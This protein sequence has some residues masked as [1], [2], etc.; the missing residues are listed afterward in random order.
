MTIPLWVIG[1]GG[2]ASVVI[3][4]ARASGQF[5]IAGVLDDDARRH[6]A[7]VLGEPVRGDSS[8]ETVVALSV[9]HVVIAIGANPV[10]QRVAQRLDGLVRWARVVH[11]AAIVAPDVTIGP[12]SV[13]M[14]GAIVQPRSALGAH[15]IVNTAASVDHDCVLGAFCHVGPGAHLAGNVRVGEGALLGVGTSVIPGRSIG[16]WST[17]GAGAAVVRDLPP[18]VTA[19]GVPSSVRR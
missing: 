19:T 9:E 5:T 16:E 1:S 15:V 17:V 14:A 13:I 6:G 18:R 2:H 3:D 12:G 8:R 11:P 10:R 7:R 4:A